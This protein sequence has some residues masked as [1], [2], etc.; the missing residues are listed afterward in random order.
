MIRLSLNT[1][2]IPSLALREEF[3][4]KDAK[5][6]RSRNSWS[7]F[8]VIFWK[9][10]LSSSPPRALPKSNL[11]PTYIPRT[12]LPTYIHTYHVP[13]YL[14]TTYLPTYHVPTY[15][16]TYHVPTYLPTTYLP[17]YIH[18][19]H[20]PTYLPTYHIPTYLPRTYLP[21]Y[22][23]TTY[24]EV[25]R[26]WIQIQIFSFCQY[27]AVSCYGKALRMVN[28]TTSCQSFK[29][30][31]IVNFNDRVFLTTKLLRYD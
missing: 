11:I 15:L 26:T 28:S 31:T 6:R 3:K 24:L 14:P 19:Y 1:C 18:T 4:P 2:Q 5:E 10:F 21:T 16:P 17:T 23:P 9:S 7:P 27:L 20:V 8:L 13:T 29:G 22:L 25:V 30:C 12:Y